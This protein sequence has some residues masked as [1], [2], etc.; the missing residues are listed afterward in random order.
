MAKPDWDATPADELPRLVDRRLSRQVRF[1][2]YPYGA[3]YRRVLDEAGIS[4]EG[5]SGIADLLKLPL[6][7]RGL[8]AGLQDE[9]LLIPS[10]ALIQRWGSGRQ[11][12][13][14]MMERLLRGVESADKQLRHEYEPV[15]T[16]ETTGSSGEPLQIAV[17]RRDLAVLG[18]QGR[19]MLEVAGVSAADS[20]INLLDPSSAGGFWPVWLGAVALGVRQLAPGFL[21]PEQA[22]ALIRRAGPSVLVMHPDD[23]IPI[24][25]EATEAGSS[26]VGT[27][28]LG[29]AP[30]GSI[31]KKRTLEAVGSGVRVLA[32][33][34]FAEGRTLWAECAEGA[35]QPDA[36][37]HLSP[38]MELIEMISLRTQAAVKTGEPGEIVFTGLDQR[39]TAL[40]RYRPGDVAIGGFRHGRCPYCRRSVGR[41]I[42]PI[43]RAEN[44]IELQLAGHDRTTIDVETLADALS[45]PA[46]AEWQ[47]EVGKADGDS[48]APDEL[49][50]L[51][52]AR[53]G[54]DPG[55]LAVELDRIIRT[56]VGLTPTQFVQTDRAAGGVLD[57]RPVRVEDR[58]PP[59]PSGGNGGGEEAPLVR[60]WR[61]PPS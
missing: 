5:F 42:G 34:G 1:Q 3:F 14:Q 26:S 44:L 41:L 12:S 27:L 21:Q 36:G 10:G 60:L 31:G 56:E 24:F 15:H 37:F 22:A 52:K 45:H 6:V 43:R 30:L 54:A 4:A 46:V 50:V 8:I 19:R 61:P 18:T 49:F 13:E 39:G 25:G 7:D 55:R 40:A 47:V 28:I 9:F 48:R 17:T 57:L 38:D 20:M 16:L 2:L 53:S 29:P 51:F 59:V 11:L 32:T 33:Y 23:V 58:R 35:G